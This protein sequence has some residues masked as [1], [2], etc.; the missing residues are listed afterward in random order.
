MR[1]AMQTVDAT[2]LKCPMPLLKTKLALADMQTGEQVQ[3]VATDIGST[4]DIPKFVDRA[5][6]KLVSLNEQNHRH[7][8][9]IEKG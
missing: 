4:K 9:V 6:H 7:Y 8:F 5:G 1:T 3:V 2:D